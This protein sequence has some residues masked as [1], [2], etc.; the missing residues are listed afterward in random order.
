LFNYCPQ[1]VEN[2]KSKNKGGSAFLH[3]IVQGAIYRKEKPTEESLATNSAG[4]KKHNNMSANLVGIYQF[5]AGNLKDNIRNL[6]VKQRF[7]S[8]NKPSRFLVAILQD[9]SEKYISS[10]Y[11][12]QSINW[13]TN[14]QYQFDYQGTYYLLTIDTWENKATIDKI[15]TK[16]GILAKKREWDDSFGQ[17]RRRSKEAISDNLFKK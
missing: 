5:E 9:G 12:H 7:Q 4:L 17:S 10:L 8:N 3:N 1:W 15:G 14:E 16:K 2:L 11:V 13:T 6:K